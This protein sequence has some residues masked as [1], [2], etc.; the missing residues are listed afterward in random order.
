M[1]N[2]YI[3]TYNEP[4]I[5][6]KAELNKALYKNIEN[7]AIDVVYVVDEGEHVFTSDKV[8]M[9]RVNERA[10]FEYMFRLMAEMSGDDDV[11]ILVNSDIYFDEQGIG[12]IQARLG[13]DMCYALTRYDIRKDGSVDFVNRRDSQDSWCFRGKVRQVMADYGQGI[14]GCDNNIAYKLTE[15]GYTVT[16]PSLTIR[17]YHV[18]ASE[19]RNWHDKGSVSAPYLL[20]D[21]VEI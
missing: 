8:K 7:P 1:T 15:V 3:T 14:A 19:V 4:N 9:V 6:R 16:N 17:S 5:E 2:L 13:R 21:C 10:T 18:H 11:N 12:I 20:L